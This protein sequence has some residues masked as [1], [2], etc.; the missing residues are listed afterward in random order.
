MMAKRIS[1]ARAA[2]THNAPHRRDDRYNATASVVPWQMNISIETELKYP[3]I[4]ETDALPDMQN[5]IRKNPNVHVYGAVYMIRS[6]C[7]ALHGRIA[8]RTPVFSLEKG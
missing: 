5:T 3:V 1:Q 8:L 2:M 6:G 4:R 7:V